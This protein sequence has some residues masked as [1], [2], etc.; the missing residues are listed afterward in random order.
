[1]SNELHQVLPDSVLVSWSPDDPN[2]QWGLW[3]GDHGDRCPRTVVE[4]TDTGM[5]RT[6]SS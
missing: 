3:S 6:Q 1:M 5:A 4:M 2:G